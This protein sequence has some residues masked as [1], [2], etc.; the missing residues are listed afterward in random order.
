VELNGIEPCGAAPV[1]T[2]PNALV[3]CATM[4]NQAPPV[5][6]TPAALDL[7]LSWSGEPSRKAAEAFDVW[8]K[9]MVPGTATWV[10]SL[11]IDSGAQSREEVN[12]ALRSCKYGVAFVTEETHESAWINFEAGALWNSL[13]DQNLIHV[14]LLDNKRVDLKKPLG[15]FQST[16][17]EAEDM[18]KLVTGVNRASTR[19]QSADNLRIVFDARWPELEASL[20]KA[21]Q[22]A[23]GVAAKP[24]T[25][26]ATDQILDRLASSDRTSAQL[27]ALMGRV[28]EGLDTV[29]RR[30][31]PIQL[32]PTSDSSVGAVI[33]AANLALSESLAVHHKVDPFALEFPDVA[34]ALTYT[35][36][37][38]PLPKP[39]LHRR[40]PDG[41]MKCGNRGPGLIPLGPR[42]KRVP[43]IL[44]SQC[45]DSTEEP[46]PPPLPAE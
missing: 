42:S 39:T 30:L 20:K 24:A 12:R 38:T 3:T 29:V 35:L 16:L 25:Q 8:I 1:S 17:V 44:C 31:T 5:P 32:F 27:L 23:S 7:F 40:T 28:Q 22:G 4:D 15:S 43:W 45:F 36:G 33:A 6:T 18:F 19:P 41:S 11:N 37:Q 13:A 21:I 2:P 46:T 26:S 34:S 9:V 10:S 14:V